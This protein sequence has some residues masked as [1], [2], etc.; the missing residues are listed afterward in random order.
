MSILFVWSLRYIS[1]NIDSLD[2][3]I[4]P[5]NKKKQSIVKVLLSSEP[6]ATFLISVCGIT[7]TI[8]DHIRKT[9]P[10]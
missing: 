9:I 8:V 4:K 7:I 5:N 6:T 10:L 3:W 2:V 1:R